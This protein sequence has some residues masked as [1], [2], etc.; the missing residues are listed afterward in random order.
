MQRNSNK[1]PRRE[2]FKSFIDNVG[3]RFR[4]ESLKHYSDE[5][6]LTDLDCKVPE[7]ERL[8]RPFW[9]WTL[10]EAYIKLCLG[11]GFEFG[12]ALSRE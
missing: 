9:T 4:S 7:C 6:Q 2:M 12:L 5:Q 1:V 3:V 10:K 8:K 11:L